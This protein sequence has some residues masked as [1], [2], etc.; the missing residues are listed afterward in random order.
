MPI[1]NYFKYYVEDIV[2]NK[3]INLQN[4][5]VRTNCLDSLDRTN[6][7]QT[8]VAC[9]VLSTILIKCGIDLRKVFGK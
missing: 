2:E 4:G 3:V 7:I 1:C 6:L 9:N 5:V 8:K